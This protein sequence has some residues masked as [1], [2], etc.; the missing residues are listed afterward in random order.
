[1]TTLSL[2]DYRRD[3]D[4]RPDPIPAPSRFEIYDL[5]RTFR[6]DPETALKIADADAATAWSNRK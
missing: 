6:T 5:A 3:R 4:A 1:M 2:A